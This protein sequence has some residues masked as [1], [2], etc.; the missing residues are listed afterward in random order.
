MIP[1]GKLMKMATGTL[2]ADDIMET[3]SSFGAEAAFSEVPEDRKADAFQRVA[4]F[5]MLPD[6]QLMHAT[7]LL[8]DGTR[9]EMIGVIRSPNQSNGS[10][11][12][13][14]IDEAESAALALC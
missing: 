12:K 7:V 10:N 8:K 4:Q 11:T 5:S 2:S 3:I 13:K 9:I 14:S 6:A 1:I